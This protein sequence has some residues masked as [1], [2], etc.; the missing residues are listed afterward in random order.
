MNDIFSF[1][2]F[3]FVFKKTL[4]ERPVQLL[5]LCVLSLVISFL[6][7][8]II[9]SL[10]GF[11]DAQNISFIIGLVGCGTF[12]ASF[13]FN[14]FSANASGSSYLTLPA[15]SLEKWLSGILIAS[16]LFPAL[17]VV[18]FHF[19]DYAF[20]LS[21]RHSLDPKGPFYKELYE[22]VN[23][24]P[25]FGFVASKAYMMFLNATGAMLVGSLYFNRGAYIKV[26]LLVCCLYI[27]GH[28]FNEV[29]A[30]AMFDKI[31]KALPYYFVF[32][33]VGKE[34]GK[35]LLPNYASEF[36]DVCIMYIMPAIFWLTAFVRLREKEF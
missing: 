32:I 35:V 19:I 14:Y 23:T 27:G 31:D 7:Y 6:L 22:R 3:G 8:A 1:R 15:S 17:F 9:K 18:F 2:R 28:V 33:P 13:V 24:F 11:D 16:V 12:L 21:Y 36:V 5:G 25:I 20:V 10:V 34:F 29:I 30:N 26:A 4:L